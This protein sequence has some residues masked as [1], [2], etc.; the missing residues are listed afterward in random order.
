M[1]FKIHLIEVLVYNVLNSNTQITT[2]TFLILN[3]N[4]FDPNI[5]QMSQNKIISK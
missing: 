2:T 4:K 5:I 3:L 1:V